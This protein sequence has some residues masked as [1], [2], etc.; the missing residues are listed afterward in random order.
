MDDIMI[1][2]PFR[3]QMRLKGYNYS[4]AGYYYITIC[5][6]N[7]R[8][9]LGHVVGGDANSSQSELFTPPSVQLSDNGYIVKKYIE[10]ISLSHRYV[11]VDKYVIMPNHIH[12]IIVL[13][14][15]AMWSSPPTNKIPSIMR[16]FKTMITK[17]IGVSL[18]QESYYDH[19]IRDENDY[20]TKW[21]YIDTNPA[22]WA[23][24]E[25]FSS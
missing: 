19:I 12:M 17:E 1:D 11:D 16:S 14:D 9:I 10:G 20:L 2:A 22:K 18:F 13:K 15:G 21:N 3:K 24:D 23:E 5:T 8:D 7:R 4:Q 25:Y 6:M